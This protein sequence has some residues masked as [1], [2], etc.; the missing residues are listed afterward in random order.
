MPSSTR[1]LALFVVALLPPAACSNTEKV[2][3]TP[4]GSEGADTQ[5]DAPTSRRISADHR[6]DRC[7]ALLSG[8]QP[9]LC[10]QRPV[11][12]GICD[13]ASATC[14]ASIN[15]CALTGG[16]CLTSTNAALSSVPAACA[17][18]APAW[19]TARRASI[20]PRAA[21]ARA[22]PVCARR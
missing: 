16:P 17:A 21:A 6:Q 18:R 22:T 2:G 5:N 12:L 4:D 8:D 9:D 19:P 10:P 13:P 14:A 20:P 7:L 11:L 1:L 3:D 15:K